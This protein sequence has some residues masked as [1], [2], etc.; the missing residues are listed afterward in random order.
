VSKTEHAFDVHAFINSRPIGTVQYGIVVPCGLVMFLDGL[1]T[2]A[3]F[4][5]FPTVVP[6]LR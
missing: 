4:G 6:P 2:Q 5:P 1:D 3:K